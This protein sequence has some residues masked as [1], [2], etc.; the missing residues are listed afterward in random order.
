MIISVSTHANLLKVSLSVS[1][2]LVSEKKFRFQKFWSRKIILVSVSEN[3]VTEKVLVSKNLVYEKIL[4]FGKI[5]ICKKFRFRFRKFWY[6]KQKNRV[7]RRWPKQNQRQRDYCL[8]LSILIPELE[9]FNHWQS[10]FALTIEF[11]M[12]IRIYCDGYQTWDWSLCLAFFI[13][14]Y[15]SSRSWVAL[16]FKV[17]Q[18]GIES[19]RRW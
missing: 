2:I 1:G 19:V 12:S 18:S 9:N 14:R 15:R 13:L 10:N 6:W 11:R 16:S 5:D 4:G 8:L 3:F 7:A 17:C